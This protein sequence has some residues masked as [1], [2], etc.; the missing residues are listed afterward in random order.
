MA[1]V[2]RRVACVVFMVILL[3]AAYA[4]QGL[5]TAA[6][7][8]YEGGAT[9]LPLIESAAQ[10]MLVGFRAVVVDVFWM[11]ASSLQE[12]GQ[13][14]EAVTKFDKITKLQPDLPEVWHFLVWNIMY[15]LPYEVETIEDKWNLIKL[16][17]TYADEAAKRCPNSGELANKIGFMVWHRF[18]DRTFE[19]AAYLRRKFREWKGETNFEAAIQW[20]E[21]AI[22]SEDFKKLGVG[23]QEI[24]CRQITHTLDRWTSQAFA[25]G[26][27]EMALKAAK[28]AVEKWEWVSKLHPGDPAHP[29][30]D[31]NLERLGH[32]KKRLLAVEE[33]IA[34]KKAA[35]AG[36]EAEAIEHARLSADAWQW[37]VDA[38]P[39]GP[40]LP[41]LRKAAAWLER[42]KIEKEK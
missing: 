18:D 15:N 37:L 10:L 23:T 3:A 36:N 40:D 7:N 34:S 30:V 22:R 14:D 39:S 12:D 11:Q 20:H 5:L 38:W 28:L 13:I 42:L 21:K 41:A 31:I 9:Q 6:Q 24:W 29:E 32:A 25:D 33:S 19:E 1:G 8:E 17:L 4:V 35:D 2:K 27:L 16:G 26:E